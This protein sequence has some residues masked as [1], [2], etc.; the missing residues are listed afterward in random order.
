MTLSA[1]TSKG[2]RVFAPQVSVREPYFCCHCKK[3]MSWVDAS[4]K[5]KHFRHKVKADCDYEPET[6]EH[7]QNVWLVYQE[8]KYLDLGLAHLEHTIDNVRADIF[9]ERSPK[10]GIA[11]E[12]Q[13]TNYDIENYE[14]KIKVY[15]RKNFLVLYIFIGN[16]FMR[17]VKPNIFSLKEIERRIFASKNYD[18]TVI[19]CYFD[20]ENITVP[21]YSKKWASGGGYCTH[22]YIREYRNTKKYRLR[23]Y[24]SILYHHYPKQPYF[25]VCF[26]ENLHDEEFEKRN[27]DRWRVYLCEDC[28]RQVRFE[29]IA[30]SNYSE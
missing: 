25:R 26:H 19:G 16:N 6:V 14:N 17:E 10:I 12:V 21:S 28:C 24:L 20:G 18:H 8:L 7:D 23:D 1:N 22:R 9:W 29:R 3:E 27:G 11:I 5:I 13:A 30:D 4:L 15:A 2:T